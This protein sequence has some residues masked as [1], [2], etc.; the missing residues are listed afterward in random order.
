M[1]ARVSPG[2]R[3]AVD[4]SNKGK[5]PFAQRLFFVAGESGKN[6]L[7]LGIRVAIVIWNHE[8]NLG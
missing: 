7:E 6:A 5:R 8:E 3:V 2:E 4:E 1:Y